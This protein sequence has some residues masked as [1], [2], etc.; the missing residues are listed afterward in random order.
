M[1]SRNVINNSF[2]IISFIYSNKINKNR[3]VIFIQLR[4]I[5]NFIILD[6]SIKIIIIEVNN[7]MMMYQFF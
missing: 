1:V 7:P 3:T 4:K 6:V 2:L 5:T